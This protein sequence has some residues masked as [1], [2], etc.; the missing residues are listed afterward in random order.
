MG[1]IRF[2]FYG[3]RHS[4]KAICRLRRH[5]GLAQLSW[6]LKRSLKRSYATS[7]LSYESEHSIRR[8]IRLKLNFKWFIH[9]S[10]LVWCFFLIEEL[11]QDFVQLTSSRV[12]CKFLTLLE[13]LKHI[14]QACNSILHR[15]RL[16]DRKSLFWLFSFVRQPE[17]ST[18][19]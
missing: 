11:N 18:T 14:N 13:K 8:I 19:H 5:F 4:C 3:F 12:F 15:K 16:V 10:C 9:I 6:S 2:D 17:L 1:W 7:K